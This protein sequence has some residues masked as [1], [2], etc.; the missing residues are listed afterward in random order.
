MPAKKKR[1]PATPTPAAKKKPPWHLG[2]ECSAQFENAPS[3]RRLFQGRDRG[4]HEGRSE[5]SW[6]GLPVRDY[7]A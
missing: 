7:V 6:R 3:T 2:C 4:G 1:V 5:D